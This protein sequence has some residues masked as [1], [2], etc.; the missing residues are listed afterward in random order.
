MKGHRLYRQIRESLK[1]LYPVEPTG[2][3]ARHLNTLTGFICG[4]IQSNRVNLPAVAS[5]LPNV[6]KEQSRVAQLKRWLTNKNV[7]IESYFLPFIEPLLR[8]LANNQLVLVI[9]GSTVGR[10]CVTLMVS[11]VYKGR[12]LPLLWV[13][14]KGKKGHFPEAMHIDLI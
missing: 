10:E 9:D 11:V 5:E 1:K 3:L 6:G 2:N 7:N 13:T 8:C 12:A 4:I 14:R